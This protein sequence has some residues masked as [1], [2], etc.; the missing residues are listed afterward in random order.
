MQDE[1]SALDRDGTPRQAGEHSHQRKKAL[2][3]DSALAGYVQLR[4]KGGYACRDGCTMWQWLWSLHM[5]MFVQSHLRQSCSMHMV[6][7]H[8]VAHVHVLSERL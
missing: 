4:P 7:D 8:A 2:T 6:V 1:V 5:W 3:V